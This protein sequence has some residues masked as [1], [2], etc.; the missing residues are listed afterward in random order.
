MTAAHVSRKD[1]TAREVGPAAS[2]RVVAEGFVY[3]RL[4]RPE[5][6]PALERRLEEEHRK[7][8][9]AAQGR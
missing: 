3:A 2:T 8:H 1:G 6:F 5:D 7:K 9:A 4:R